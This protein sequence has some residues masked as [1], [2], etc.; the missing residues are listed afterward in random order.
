MAFKILWSCFFKRIKFTS[1]WYESQVFDFTKF[2]DTEGIDGNQFR[3]VCE[4]LWKVS[5]SLGI[6]IDIYPFLASKLEFSQ[7]Y[8]RRLWI[9]DKFGEVHFAPR[10][11]DGNHKCLKKF[12]SFSCEFL[13]S[14]LIYRSMV[15]FQ[16]P[17][18]YLYTGCFV[19]SRQ[20]KEFSITWFLKKS[21]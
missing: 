19:F 14:H 7:F 20:P 5:A 2:F 10:Y 3:F 4:T 13:S 8:L 1:A 9:N 15:F 6:E 16:N 11:L 18:I 12:L 17:W 21:F